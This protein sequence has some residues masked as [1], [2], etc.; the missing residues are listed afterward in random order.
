MT[1]FSTLFTLIDGR[2][3]S[4]SL[5]THEASVETTSS[6]NAGRC[7]TNVAQLFKIADR[8]SGLLDEGRFG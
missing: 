7:F 3:D 1:D 5:G 2:E 4:L 8:M 6:T